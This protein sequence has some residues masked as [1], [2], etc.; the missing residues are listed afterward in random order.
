MGG[1][2]SPSS[3]SSGFQPLGGGDRSSSRS[4]LPIYPVGGQRGLHETLSKKKS[5]NNCDSHPVPPSCSLQR[6]LAPQRERRVNCTVRTSGTSKAEVSSVRLCPAPQ[7]S[8]QVPC[9]AP[10]QPQ[11]NMPSPW[12]PLAR[13]CLR[14]PLS[15][16]PTSFLRWLKIASHTLTPVL[17]LLLNPL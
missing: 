17:F 16:A 1:Q 9:P 8:Q 5:V 7:T 12:G 15:P 4:S 14:S 2:S 3:R 10:Q 11:C 13:Y 6:P